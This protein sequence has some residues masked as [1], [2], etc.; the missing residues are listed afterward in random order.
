[1]GDWFE[2]GARG[3]RLSVPELFTAGVCDALWRV[4]AA[5]GL[6]SIGLT[7]DGGACSLT[8]TDDGRWKREYFRDS[9]ELEVFV[10]AAATFLESDGRFASS[11]NGGRRRSQ[12]LRDR[13]K[14]R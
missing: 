9:D 11:E 3:A 12:P 1:M 6:V 5:G 4:V 2:D 14:S 10:L 8:V 7:S 13:Q